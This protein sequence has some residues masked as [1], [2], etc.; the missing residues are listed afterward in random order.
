M[1]RSITPLPRTSQIVWRKP[2]EGVEAPDHHQT[3][4]RQCADDGQEIGIPVG[5]PA[6]GLPVEQGE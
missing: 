1:P 2:R 4:A 5:Q 6:Y 3:K